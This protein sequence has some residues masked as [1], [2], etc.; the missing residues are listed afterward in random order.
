MSEHPADIDAGGRAILDR[1]ACQG[2][3]REIVQ[4]D[5]YGS[6]FFTH[7]SRRDCLTWWH[8][9]QLRNVTHQATPLRTARRA[10]RVTPSGQGDGS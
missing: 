4:V 7:K 3:G 5:L 1:D 2:C 10:A 8:V 6:P 9:E